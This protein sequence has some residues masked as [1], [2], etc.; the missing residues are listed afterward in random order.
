MKKRKIVKMLALML[1]LTTLLQGCQK[2]PVSNEKESQQT[3]N[4]QTSSEKTS[5]ATVVEES[6]YPEYLNMDSAYPVIK[7][8]YAGDI[9]LNLAVVMQ[10]SHGEWDDLW[11]S[12]YLKEKY[13]L[14]FNVEIIETSA[15]AEK[16]SLLMSS[17]ELP[18]LMWNLSFSTTE[19]V[20]YGQQ[21]EM[22]LK[23][24][25]YMNE[26]LTPNIL[27]YFSDSVRKACTA[28]DGHIYSM[29]SLN[30][31]PAENSGSAMRIYIYQPWLDELQL[32]IPQT[33][34][35]FTSTMYAIKKANLSGVGSENIYPIGG[36]MD[37]VTCT[38]YLLNAFGYVMNDVG[39]VKMNNG[40]SYGFGP[41]LRDGEVV[42]PVYDMEVYQNFLKL[43]NQYYKDGIINPNYFT[44]SG[45]DINSQ[46]TSGQ[47]AVF[48]DMSSNMAAYSEYSDKENKFQNW[49][50]CIPLTS[51]W[52]T[53]PEMYSPSACSVGNFVISADTEYPELCM[54]IADMFFNN[55]DDYC[56]AFWGGYGEGSEWD[57]D[58]YLQS[59]W[60][61]ETQKWNIH[62]NDLPQG[63]SEW[64]NYIFYIHG[65]MPG[66]GAYN[67]TESRARL[68]NSQGGNMA[69]KK[70]YDLNSSDWLNYSTEQNLMPYQT[71]T[72]PVIYYLDDATS[73]KMADLE[74][75][76]APY[77]REQV[78]LF[79]TGERS[80]SE[81]DK[82]VEELEALGIKDLL[83]IYKQIYSMQ[84]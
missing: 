74:T 12:W 34:D 82:F 68:A 65:F 36:S 50:S 20:K 6:K 33:L 63:L 4:T 56:R 49:V 53:E 35:D 69:D 48:S 13:N 54:R 38:D 70:V 79:I 37:T 22:F 39:L 61:P 42:I 30:G 15:L 8:E 31:D 16:K 23:M 62:P 75:V 72:F 40:Y 59:K 1:A 19:L 41:T 14:E 71:E 24:D 10:P 77:V 45:T 55:T 81:T 73:V 21:E 57:T 11:L 80:L 27:H 32:E 7:D 64:S 78:A 44:I 5:E 17:G 26:E 76:I 46:L 29:P 28:G 25:E 18:D 83:D 9:K 84:Q 51:E 66:F 47:T 58:E 2:A 3:Q 52:Q 67:L 43:M 60:N